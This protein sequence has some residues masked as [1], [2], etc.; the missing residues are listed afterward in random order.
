MEVA[1]GPFGSRR[2]GMP[3][4]RWARLMCMVM[5]RCVGFLRVGLARL[6][7]AILMQLGIRL[8]V[9][10][11]VRILL[12]YAVVADYGWRDVCTRVVGTVVVCCC[13]LVARH[14]PWSSTV[15]LLIL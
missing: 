15:S 3:L 9:I 10:S 4:T 1:L 8:V 11:L 14:W 13:L 6:G 5:S 7:V 2:I 12:W